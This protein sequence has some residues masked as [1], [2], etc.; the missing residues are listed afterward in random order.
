MMATEIIMDN[1]REKLKRAWRVLLFAS[2]TLLPAACS[3]G[4]E[5]EAADC[6]EDGAGDVS[7]VSLDIV[8]TAG[9]DSRAGDPTGGEDGDCREPGQDYENE[10]TTVTAFVMAG[11]A[12]INAQGTTPI[13]AVIQFYSLTQQDDASATYSRAYR[14]ETLPVAIPDGTYSVLAVANGGDMAWATNAANLTL[15]DVRD[16]IYKGY[17]GAAWQESAGEY[18]QFVMASADD[19]KLTL[20]SNS[21]DEPAMA[22]IGVE[23]LA[24]RVDYQKQ[25]SYTCAEGAVFRGTVEIEGAVLVNNM[26]AGSYLFKRTA[27]DAKGTVNLCYLGR[28]TAPDGVATNYV[29]DPWT[30]RKTP[31]MGA[32]PGELYG[33]RLDTFATSKEWAAVIGRGTPVTDVVSGKEWL[34]IGYTLENTADRTAEPRDYATG[35]VFRARFT[36]DE[37][38]IKGSYTARHT[39]FRWNGALY[40]TCRD[41]MEAY[42]RAGSVDGAERDVKACT[43][44][45][46]LRAVA[47]GLQ[48]GDPTGYVSWLRACVDGHSND[49]NVLTDAEQYTWTA[50]MQTVC[51]YRL[52]EQGKVQI[53]VGG[54]NTR[55]LLARHNV[56]TYRDATCYYTYWIRHGG[57]ESSDAT[58]KHAVVRN[59]IY[60][61]SVDGVYDLGDDLPG[62][63]PLVVTVYVN[64]WTLLP[65]ESLPM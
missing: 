21:A 63:T 65:E 14:T 46:D 34:R 35:V 39:F 61:L 1:A 26:T 4:E 47:N 29:I 41:I 40:A 43:T 55:E 33:L 17:K 54:K 6:D 11:D 51:G 2:C 23:R 18:G 30:A 62:E 37:D 52:D 59:N 25:G 45:D 60:K 7:Y 15:A 57:S 53:D 42:W 3:F 38:A 58:M 36:P 5:F 64:N 12:G 22:E 24:A 9:P 27:D 13:E 10:V 20:S 19:A 49:G 32:L 28:E 8:P 50:Y 31:N 56:Q 16:H 48:A 44:W